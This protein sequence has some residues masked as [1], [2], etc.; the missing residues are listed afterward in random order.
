MKA[1]Y[2][3]RAS[4]W[5]G[6]SCTS[7]CICV[8]VIPCSYLLVVVG[9]KLSLLQ[10]DAHL[11]HKCVNWTELLLWPCSVGHSVCCSWTI[12]L[13]DIFINLSIYE[14]KTDCS[15]SYV[16]MFS[17]TL[18]LLLLNHLL[19]WHSHKLVFMK[20]LIVPF[21]MRLHSVVSVWC[22]WIVCLCDTLMNLLIIYE[23]KNW[24]FYFICDYVQLYIQFVVLEPNTC[25]TFWYT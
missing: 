22:H 20:T 19:M 13:C 12:C 6:N 10:T 1:T 8:C 9:S 11:V 25:L 3:N 18:S 14:K 23:K 15:I 16:T 24:L 7:D 21:H 17:C 5:L 4:C 2:T